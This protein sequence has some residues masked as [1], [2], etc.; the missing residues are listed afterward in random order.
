MLLYFSL[1]SICYPFTSSIFL[2]IFRL[3]QENKILKR[4]K[5][6]A[7]HKYLSGRG[8]FFT[9]RK[10]K[11]CTSQRQSEENRDTLSDVKKRHTKQAEQR[12]KIEELVCFDFVV[13]QNY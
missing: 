9:N 7:G 4:F 8:N 1:T 2:K 11:D 6:I 3:C 13:S 12:K 10:K 5:G